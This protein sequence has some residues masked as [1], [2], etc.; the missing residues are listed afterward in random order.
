M[1]DAKWTTVHLFWHEGDR[2]F[3]A[4]DPFPIGGVV[5]DAA[6][7]AAAAA[8]GGY[9]REIGYAH[10]GRITIEQGVDMGRPSLLQVD[11]VPDAPRVRVTGHAV[12]I[13]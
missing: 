2:H 5:E 8:F 3:Q 13:E 1:R 11:L 4:R 12:P 6:T 9:L 7:G 10:S